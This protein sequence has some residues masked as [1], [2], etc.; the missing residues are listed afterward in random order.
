MIYRILAFAGIC[1]LIIFYMESPKVQEI[2]IRRMF[3]STNRKLAKGGAK[4]QI[5]EAT[6]K[7][8]LTLY[9][10]ESYGWKGTRDYAAYSCCTSIEEEFDEYLKNGNAPEKFKPGNYEM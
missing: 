9:E 3:K 1:G 8:Y 5:D 7:K 10:D 6:I 2:S 4:F